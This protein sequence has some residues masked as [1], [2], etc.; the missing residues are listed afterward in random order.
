MGIEENA[1]I[2]N[3]WRPVV[4]CLK[5]WLI[6]FGKRRGEHRTTNMA[7]LQLQLLLS[8][9]KRLL[10]MA[11]GAPPMVVASVGPNVAML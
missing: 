5:E 9:S 11:S 3:F 6:V 8:L 7:L 1:D 4:H 10:L 2:V